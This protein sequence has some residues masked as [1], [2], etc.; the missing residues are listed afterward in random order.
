MPNSDGVEMA[1]SCHPRVPAGRIPAEMKS[2]RFVLAA[3]PP[4]Q[5]ENSFL[6]GPEARARPN[7]WV[8][9]SPEGEGAGG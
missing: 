7:E 4:K 2:F 9:H 3:L 8:M 6:Q 5:T 1:T